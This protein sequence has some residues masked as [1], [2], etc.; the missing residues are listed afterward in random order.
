MGSGGRF[1]CGVPG[2]GG[3]VRGFGRSKG[4][5]GGWER[6][7]DRFS[8]AADPAAGEPERSLTVLSDD[9]VI[10]AESSGAFRD[11]VDAIGVVKGFSGSG[12]TGNGVSFS[13]SSIATPSSEEGIM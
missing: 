11:T 12:V 2:C 6:D 4:C 1:P 9:S 10:I 7:F 3:G 5:G 8:A 13:I